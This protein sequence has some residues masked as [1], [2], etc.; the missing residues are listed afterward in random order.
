MR[1]ICPGCGTTA[2]AEVWQQDVFARQVQPVL[3]KMPGIVQPYVLGYLALFRKDGR[4]L[5]WRKTLKVVTALADLIGSRKVSWER[6]EERPAPPELWARAMDAVL[7]RSPKGLTNHNYLR[8]TAFEMAS[9]LAAKTEREAEAEKTRRPY[10]GPRIDD[11][12]P[13]S[14]EL[15]EAVRQQLRDFRKSFG[16]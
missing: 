14:E 1:L 4:A 16:G 11:E 3:L 13:A 9:G 6:S 7:D 8:H 10:D 2:S 5:P 12:A 15:R